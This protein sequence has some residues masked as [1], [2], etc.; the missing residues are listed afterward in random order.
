MAGREERKIKDKRLLGIYG[1][2]AVVYRCDVVCCG[3]DVRSADGRNGEYALDA[4]R[5]ETGG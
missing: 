2:D 5:D 3:I 1:I 4:R